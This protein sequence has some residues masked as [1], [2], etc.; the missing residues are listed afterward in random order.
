MATA[1][2][3]MVH[4]SDYIYPAFLNPPFP[5]IHTVSSPLAFRSLGNQ[6]LLC[7]IK[8]VG[9]PGLSFQSL[10]HFLIHIGGNPSLSILKHFFSLP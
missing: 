3:E 5:A 10:R 6:I 2:E 8:D 4:Y 9:F 7:T 1:S